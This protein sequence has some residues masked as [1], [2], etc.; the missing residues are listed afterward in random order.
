MTYSDEDVR[1]H[2]KLGEDSDWEFKE[3]RFKD[4]QPASPKRDDWADEIAAFANT[5]GGV[6]LCGVA[7]DGRVQ[8]MSRPETDEL[9]K[10][11]DGVCH[12]PIN[13]PVSVHIRRMEPEENGII[14]VVEIQQGYALHASSRGRYFCRRGSSRRRMNSDEALRLAQQ[15]GQARFQWFD[16]QPLP[17]TGFHT[18]SETLWKTLLSA[19][20][21]ADPKTA[22][23]KLALLAPDENNTMRATVAG[24]LL[25][26][27]HPEE[28][29]PNACITAT[30]YRGED[31]ASD[32][33]DAQEITG[34]LDRQI[35]AAMNFVV[36]TCRLQRAK[37]PRESICPSTASERC[38]RRWSTPWFIAITPSAAAGPA[39]PCSRTA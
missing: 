30:R 31:R 8:G 19:E 32:Q 4:N 39:C 26:S 15:R 37:P 18:L 36:T 11:L 29:L 3:V 13:P 5:H 2:L 16:E 28:W 24:V 20:S 38:S 12:D 23:E 14:L 1:H 17:D 27:E 33:I 21:A 7:D 35:G 10:L 25:C 22:L 34:S 9:M 6:I